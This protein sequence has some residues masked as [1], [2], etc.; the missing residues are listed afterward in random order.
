MFTPNRLDRAL[1]QQPDA[2]TQVSFLGRERAEHSADDEIRRRAALGA[3]LAA[4]LVDRLLALDGT[5]KA[6]EGLRWQ[7]ESTLHYVRDLPRED[8]ESAYLAAIVA[9]VQPGPGR[10]QPVPRWQGRGMR[11]ASRRSA[12]PSACRTERGR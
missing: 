3:Y 8:T 6:E 10:R 1:A 2:A 9:A 5:E 7:Q 4:R 12:S 11:F